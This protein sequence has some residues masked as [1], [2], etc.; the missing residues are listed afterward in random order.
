MLI[1]ENPKEFAAHLQK[2][3]GVS[4]WFSVTQAQ[5]NDFARSTGDQQWIHVDEQRC[6]TDSPFGVPIAHGFLLLSMYPS[7]LNGLLEVKNVRLVLN[8]GLNKV[9]FM[10]PILVNSEL[11][12]SAKL[13]DYQEDKMGIKVSFSLT[14]EMKGN[15]KPVC[16]AEVLSLFQ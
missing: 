5:I 4:E 2:Q 12:M 11:R 3:I 9:R 16:V 13:I 7:L 6:K 1:L 14:F 8:Y 10:S 15:E